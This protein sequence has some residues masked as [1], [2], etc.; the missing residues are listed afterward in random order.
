M[1][2]VYNKNEW[3]RSQD[4]PEYADLA[5]IYSK[6]MDIIYANQEPVSQALDE[7]AEEINQCFK[8]STYRDTDEE[9][10]VID[11]LFKN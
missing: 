5:N 2:D 9:Q 4:P 6:Y 7:A 1:Y 10:A 3:R 8:N 11:S